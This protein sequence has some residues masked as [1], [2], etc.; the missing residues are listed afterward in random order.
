MK[1]EYSH[2]LYWNTEPNIIYKHRL[3]AKKHKFFKIKGTAV[4]SLQE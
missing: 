2:M 3:S 4:S 1:H